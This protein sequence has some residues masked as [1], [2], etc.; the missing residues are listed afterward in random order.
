MPEISEPTSSTFTLPHQARHLLRRRPGLQAASAREL[1]AEPTTSTPSSA[2]TTRA[3]RARTSTLLE[4]AP[5][6]WGLSELRREAVNAQEPFPYDQRGR[7]RARA[8][9]LHPAGEAG[10]AVAA[11]PPDADDRPARC[12]G[13][14]AR[15][16]VEAY[17][18]KIME[19][20]VGTGPFMLTS[21][22]AARASCWSATRTTASVLLRRA[23][24]RPT[25]RARRPSP[26]S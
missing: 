21:G 3:G 14:M 17:G 15:E 2:T 19:H 24:A 8:R 25:T 5:R 23:G 13:A 26:P 4:N 6:C 9:P 22:G 11:L 16:V 10:R 7:G 12:F 1:V 18:D 20:P